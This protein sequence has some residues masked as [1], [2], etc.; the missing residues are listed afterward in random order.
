M[1]ETETL[2][3]VDAPHF[4]AGLVLRA[5]RVVAAAPIIG[6]MRGWP[7]VRAL[8]YCKGRHWRITERA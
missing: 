2:V 1:K 3:V 7:R 8:A 5:D 4:Y 6:Y